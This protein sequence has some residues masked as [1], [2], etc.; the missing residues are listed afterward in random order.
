MLSMGESRFTSSTA[1]ATTHTSRSRS[2]PVKVIVCGVPATSGAGNPTTSTAASQ[3]ASVIASYA[4]RTSTA[5]AIP[6][7]P[8][9]PTSAHDTLTSV[10]PAATRASAMAAGGVTSAEG[11]VTARTT[12]ERIETLPRSSRVRSANQCSVPGNSPP[13]V[14]VSGRRRG[15]MVGRGDDGR[16]RPA[17]VVAGRATGRAVV[18]RCGPRQRHRGL[19]DLRT[20]GPRT[21]ECQHEH[22]H[23]DEAREERHPVRGSGREG[24]RAPCGSW[25]GARAR[26]PRV[27]SIARAHALVRREESR[28]HKRTRVLAPRVFDDASAGT[29]PAGPRALHRARPRLAG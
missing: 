25:E 19:T 1:R 28:K 16:A 14:K 9:S 2:I 7:S 15:G 18:A 13:T 8:S 12:F 22:E 11:S 17:Q 4:Q 3:F 27:M 29:A 21:R 23:R 26:G 5:A 20:S 10:S 6:S 24:I